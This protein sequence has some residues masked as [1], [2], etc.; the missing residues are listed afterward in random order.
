MQTNKDNLV[1]SP[2]VL[3]ETFKRI[4]NQI[5]KL[6]PLREEGLDWEKPL[7]TLIEEIAGMNRLITSPEVFSLLCKLEG[8]NTLKKEEDFFFFRRT[9]FDCLNILNEVYKNAK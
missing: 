4:T 3:R 8:L 6:L 2:F 7:S 5:Y 1:I 9:I